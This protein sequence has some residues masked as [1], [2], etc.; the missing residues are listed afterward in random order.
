MGVEV[1]AGVASTGFQTKS[2]SSGDRLAT[3][4]PGS[5]ELESY[6]FRRHRGPH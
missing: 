5:N 4:L 1:T 2:N 3:R 6:T